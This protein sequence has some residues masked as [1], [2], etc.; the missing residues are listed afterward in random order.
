MKK[1]SREAILTDGESGGAAWRSAEKYNFCNRLRKYEVNNEVCR[2]RAL[3]G[4]DIYRLAMKLY[5]V[6]IG[7]TISNV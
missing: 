6:N 4:N 3:A 7:K 2:Y 1:R 5:Q